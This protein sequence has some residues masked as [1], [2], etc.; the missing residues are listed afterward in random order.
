MNIDLRTVPKKAWQSGHSAKLSSSQ[1]RPIVAVVK[2]AEQYLHDWPQHVPVK[3]KKKEHWDEVSYTILD[4]EGKPDVKRA[5]VRLRRSRHSLEDR[6]DRP[7]YV[8]DFNAH[9]AAKLAAQLLY[10]AERRLEDVHGR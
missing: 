8:P 1:A 5:A 3:D 7:S 4:D 6:P 2:I 9:T 10:L